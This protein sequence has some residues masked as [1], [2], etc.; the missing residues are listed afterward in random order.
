VNDETAVGVD[1]RQHAPCLERDAGIARHAKRVADD[2]GGTGKDIVDGLA[3]RIPEGVDDVRAERVVQ[4][5]PLLLD[6]RD[7]RSSSRSSAT[8]SAAS[9][10]TYAS[11]AT[12]TA[13]GSPT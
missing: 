10:A 8:S 3:V 9:S 6:G 5:C 7:G 11:S 4:R 1:L 12:T 2:D 13:T